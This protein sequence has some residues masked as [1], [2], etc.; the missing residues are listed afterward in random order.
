MTV[1]N[2]YSTKDQYGGFS[3]F[4]RHPFELDGK[5][6]LTTEHYFQ[7]QKFP[8][9][10]AYQ[11]KIRL[12]KSPMVAARLG[13]SRAQPIRPDWEQVKDELMKAALLAKFRQN[14]DIREILLSTGDAQLVEHTKNDRYWGDG[15][16]GSGK[17]KLGL[18]LMEIRE[19]LRQEAK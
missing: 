12:E 8:G 6:W 3:N 14:K 17:N 18:L 7:A 19:K 9:N 1:I 10:E 5:Q 16:D 4:S 2:F 13:R 11:E 15:G